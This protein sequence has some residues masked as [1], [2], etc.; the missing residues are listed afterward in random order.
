M[1]P[2]LTRSRRSSTYLL[3]WLPLSLLVA[4][5]LHSGGSVTWTEAAVLAAPLSLVYQFI[6][7]SAWYSCKSAPLERTE[8]T[9]LILTHATAA[10][11]ASFLW[12]QF[13][14]ILAA[15][16][17]RFPAF[18]GLEVHYAAQLPVL[19]AAGFLLYLLAVGY[20]YAILSLEASREAQE[21]LMEAT[22]LTRDAELKAL[23]AQVNPHFLFNSL[24]SISALTSIDP[25]KAREMCILL[26]EFLRLTL[27]LGEKSSIS[28]GEELQLL[29]RF[30]AI[31][32]VRFGSRLEMRESIQE[33]CRAALIPPLL[34][35]PLIENAVTHGIASLL[36][37]GTVSIT[38]R[39]MDSRLA[40]VIENTCDLDAAN[41]RRGGLGLP[42]VRQRL[43]ARYGKESDM[44][45][46]VENGAFRVQ[47]SLPF[48]VSA[49][50]ASEVMEQEQPR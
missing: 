20:F 24:N 8:A 50:L 30:L 35:Q 28:L 47:L 38:A 45:V 21:R 33:G 12:V 26:A 16:F 44:R 43:A 32:K 39:R 17:S 10:A 25:A 41:T 13:V 27:G 22:V 11:L 18:A 6:C 49:L 46:T 9:R 2:V 3:T 34:L 5:L 4:Y 23:K 15:G 7:L 31:E 1:H 37:G 40:M 36:D 48:E 14:K 29:E 19:F 42:N